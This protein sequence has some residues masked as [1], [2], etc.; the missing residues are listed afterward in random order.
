MSAVVSPQ[1]AVV[2]DFHSP[3]DRIG[4]VDVDG[5]GSSSLSDIEDKDGDQDNLE[6]ED[7][8][9]SDQSDE[10]DSE[11][12]TERLEDSPQKLRQHQDVVLS[13]RPDAPAYHQSP[14]KLQYEFT[15]GADEEDVESLSGDDASLSGSEKGVS[16]DEDDNDPTTNA[17]TLEGAQEET[18]KGIALDVG[19]NKRK[20]SS[21]HGVS[22]VAERDE[23]PKKRIGSIMAP[24][25]YRMDEDMEED[26][27]A[28]SEKDDSGELSEEEQELANGHDEHAIVAEE[29]DTIPS[30]LPVPEPPVPDRRQ[31]FR[32]RGVGST[33]NKSHL[34][35]PQKTIAEETADVVDGSGEN[36]EAEMEMEVEDEADSAMK[37]EEECMCRRISHL[38]M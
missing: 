30:T 9:L 18:A 24:E 4:D 10:N 21:D 32:N 37:D 35:I 23:P 3:E 25:E 20:R 1:A 16:L 12:E 19:G 33:I 34:N 38:D 11:A 17:I 27:D 8:E 6:G 14:S 28:L 5:D 2:T 7:S 36:A 29:E 22:E 31:S 15:A 26:D 13:S